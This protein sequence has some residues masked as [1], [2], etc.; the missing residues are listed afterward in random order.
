MIYKQNELKIKC[1]CGGICMYLIGFVCV[2]GWDRKTGAARPLSYRFHC[3]IA[4]QLIMKKK[5]RKD[6][7]DLKDLDN[8]Y[9]LGPQRDDQDLKRQ[10]IIKH[11]AHRDRDMIPCSWTF[12]QVLDFRLGN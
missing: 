9:E 3:K 12:I 7:Q 5:R 8:Q 4:D 2:R 1:D 6:N 11:Y 10:S